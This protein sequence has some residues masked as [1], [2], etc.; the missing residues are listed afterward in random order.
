MK[1]RLF[2]SWAVIA[3]CLMPGFLLI[4]ALPGLPGQADPEA[5][6]AAIQRRY[7]RADIIRA[8]FRQTYRAPGMDQTESGVVYLKKPG[9]MRW[10]YQK[11]ESKLFIADGRET[12]LYVPQDRQVQVRRYALEDFRSTPLQILIGGGDLL[13]NYV[14]SNEKPAPSGAGG[15]IALR[16]TPRAG[17]TEFAYIVVECS[18]GGYDLQ[19]ILI[20]EQTGNTSEF[21]FSNISINVKM[22]IKQFQFKVPKGVEV[23]RVDEK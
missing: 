23:V 21:W 14:V 9:L 8:D 16:L 3:W 17:E 6:L 5:A 4:P 11:P 18:S 2:K 1:S 19:R 15:A 20:V 22:D 13:L 12:W 7:A 10:E